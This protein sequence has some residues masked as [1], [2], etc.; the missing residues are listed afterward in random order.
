MAS[1]YKYHGAGNDFII[2]QSEEE[3][4][5]FPSRVQSLCHRNFGIGADG[6]IWVSKLEEDRIKMIYHNADGHQGSFC[7]NGARCAIS[8]AYSKSWCRNQGELIFGNQ[9][10][11][12]IV[13]N[14]HWI[15]VEFPV[16]DP[17]QNWGKGFFIDT[18]SPHLVLETDIAQLSQMDLNTVALPYRHHQDFIDRGGVNV[19]FFAIDNDQV[20]MRT[21]ERGVE[22][23]TLACGTG[24]VAVGITVMKK[25]MGGSSVKITAAGGQLEISKKEN[26]WLT[27]PAKKVFTGSI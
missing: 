2:F 25:K 17:L 6:V 21:F 10:R 19:N 26:Y 27:G 9:E 23:E 16:H 18:G 1:F 12:F 7:G 8:F 14:E 11:S 3:L 22:A 15:S 5:N 13:H 24:A 20:K 4:Q